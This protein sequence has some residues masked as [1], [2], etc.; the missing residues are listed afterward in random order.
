MAERSVQRLV[1]HMALD[2]CFSSLQE[3]T[4]LAGII[5]AAC[6]LCTTLCV[7]FSCSYGRRQLSMLFFMSV[8]QRQP[9]EV[10]KR[11]KRSA[12]RDRRRTGR[13]TA[14]TAD[15]FLQYIL[16][17]TAAAIVFRGLEFLQILS[18]V[19]MGAHFLQTV[20]TFR[21]R[22]S[23]VDTVRQCKRVLLSYRRDSKKQRC[24]ILI[25]LHFPSL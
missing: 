25:S 17:P 9:R 16:Y 4:V 14:L 1:T 24:A 2:Y 7:P 21:I 3:C 8:L 23:N 20:R 18:V 6:I 10:V 12:E 13:Q 11:N 5:I 15:R 19:Y 22:S